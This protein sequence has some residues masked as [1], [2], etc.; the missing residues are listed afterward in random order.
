M[1]EGACVTK[2]CRI[3]C[4]CMTTVILI[5]SAENPRF[6]LLAVADFGQINF[7]W[8]IRLI[9]LCLPG[10]LSNTVKHFESLFLQHFLG[11]WNPESEPPP[12]RCPKPPK[13]SFGSP[14]T[15]FQATHRLPLGSQ[16]SCQADFP[17]SHEARNSNICQAPGPP[18]LYSN[19]LRTRALV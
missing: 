10:R 19:T 6:E 2:L 18:L 15:P 3:S 17:G 13:G 8:F 1:F 14:M 4:C 12:R 5:A 9:R 11:K 16:I 7:I